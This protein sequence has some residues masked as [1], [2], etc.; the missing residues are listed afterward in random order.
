[1][2]VCDNG[3]GDVVVVFWA[4]LVAVMGGCEVRLVGLR[5]KQSSESKYDSSLDKDKRRRMTEA[6]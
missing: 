6:G 3:C 4:E 2:C 1:M 5:W